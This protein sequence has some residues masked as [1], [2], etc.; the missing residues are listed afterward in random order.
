MEIQYKF[1]ENKNG[2]IVHISN[3]EIGSIYYCPDCKEKFVFKKG[4]IRQQH[5]AHNNSTSNCTGEGYLHKT[6][7]KLLLDLIK[8]Y[9]TNKLPLE[10]YWICNVCQKEHNYNLM[11]NIL[12]VKDEYNLENCRPDIALINN[13]GKVPI[14]IEIVDKHEPENNV[15]QYCQKTNTVLIRIK[16]DTINDLENINEKIKFPSNVVFF[17]QL[18]CPNARNYLYQQQLNAQIIPNQYRTRQSGPT[19][20]Q[21]EADRARKRHYAIQSNYR[22]RAKRK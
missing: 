12:D 11:N 16:L 10:I 7:K 21:I 5:F 9:I 3:A 2:D 14:I 19:I 20:D 18:N 4:K 1:A 6:F 13:D 22:K 17:N 8:N 15:L